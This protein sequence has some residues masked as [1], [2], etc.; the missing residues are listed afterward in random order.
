MPL[1]MAR[2][3]TMGSPDFHISGVQG[4]WALGG[5]VLVPW[6]SRFLGGKV[7]WDEKR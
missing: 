6:A 5:C 4:G 2:G 7:N 1:K 3:L